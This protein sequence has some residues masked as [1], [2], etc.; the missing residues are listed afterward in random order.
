MGGIAGQTAATSG[1][2]YFASRQFAASFAL[3]PDS[4]PPN[5]A[6]ASARKKQTTSGQNALLSLISMDDFEGIRN[7]IHSKIK[8]KIDE[9]PASEEEE[10][11]G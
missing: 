6:D 1:N 8:D 2:H 9:N 3:D 11:N 5:A 7:Q 4:N 10:E